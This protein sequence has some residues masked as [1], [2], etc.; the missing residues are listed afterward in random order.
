MILGIVVPMHVADEPEFEISQ[1]T[2]ADVDAIFA[3]GTSHSEFEVSAA[4]RFYEKAELAEWIGRPEDDVVLVARNASGIV[5]FLFCKLMSS[6]WALLDNFLV[7]PDVRRH[8]CGT[9]MLRSLCAR[10]QRRGIEYLSTLADAAKPTLHE[11]LE[12]L[13]FKRQR[14]YVWFDRILDDG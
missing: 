8:G 14:P 10:L 4:I 11:T 3:F 12:H 7:R 13:R 9:A 2:A 1:A 5:G 6:H